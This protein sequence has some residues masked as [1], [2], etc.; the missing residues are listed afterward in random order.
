MDLFPLKA[1]IS[2]NLLNSCSCKMGCHNHL[3]INSKTKPDLNLKK[4]S[5]LICSFLLRKLVEDGT[6]KENFY[7]LNLH[8][9]IL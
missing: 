7:L 8:A 5:S 6:G 9:N 3:Q 4:L 2:P 1:K